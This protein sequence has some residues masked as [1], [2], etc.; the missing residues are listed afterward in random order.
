[1]V[2]HH[3]LLL[4]GLLMLHTFARA[5]SIGV[6]TTAPLDKVHIKDGDLLLENSK[7]TTVKTGRG[8]N[9][10]P[11][12]IASVNGNHN[13]SGGTANVTVS[14]FGMW[15]DIG[16]DNTGTQAFATA[17][18][19]T[20]LYGVVTPLTGVNK[21]KLE[22]RFYD[23]NGF[24]NFPAYSL[25]VYKT[26]T[27]AYREYNITIA[28]DTNGIELSHGNFGISTAAVDSLRITI[29]IPDSVI[30]GGG[31]ST[32]AGILVNLPARSSV[33]ITNYGKII[34][35]GGSGGVGEG[36]YAAGA[37]V[38]PCGIFSGTGLQ[39]GS[40]IATN[41]KLVVDNYGF[42]AGAGGGGG[43]GKKGAI[44]GANG[45]GGGAGAG[46]PIGSG[47]GFG[48]GGDGGATWQAVAPGGYCPT[49]PF[50]CSNPSGCCCGIT[51][52]YG[53]NGS[54]GSYTTG[55]NFL[56]GAGGAG[57]NGGYSGL[58]GGALGQPGQSGPNTWAPSVAG[59]AVA[60][61]PAFTGNTVNNL[62]GGTVVG[63][64]D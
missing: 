26:G 39:G 59:K 29:L 63:V 25:I 12:A 30:I 17:V 15:V 16:E 7:F 40:A 23:F 22:V 37:Y 20:K 48:F 42:I 54:K 24:E 58:S 45:G 32:G 3:K 1:L 2:M 56:P 10:A 57:V 44:A 52:P 49:D 53:T 43:G 13:L 14:N 33:K 60:S 21:T 64:V 46:W 35:R 4:I 41:T 51:A 11:I 28:D 34:G 47:Y 18:G 5:Q 61:A 31:I 38:G 8:R 27:D 50:A 62:S 6:G 19:S 36:T 9:L 55:I